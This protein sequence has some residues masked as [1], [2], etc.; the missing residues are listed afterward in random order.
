MQCIRFIDLQMLHGWDKSYLIVVYDPFNALESSA[1][2]LLRVD[3]IFNAFYIMSQ[4]K[5]LFADSK[6]AVEYVT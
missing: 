5:A 2:I 6:N 4:N 3:Y 1:N